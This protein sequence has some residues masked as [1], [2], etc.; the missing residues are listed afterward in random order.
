[1]VCAAKVIITRYISSPDMSNIASD[2]PL[3]IVQL[4]PDLE[5]GGVERGT[6]EI[7]KSAVDRGWNSW[8]VSRKGRL[9]DEL[10]ADGGH[11]IDWGIGGKHP[12]TLRW[13][14]RLMRFCRENRIDI[15]HARSR[16]PAW[17]AYLAWRMMPPTAR[18]FFVTTVHGLNSVNVYSR[19][20]T[21]GERVI[22]VSKTAHEF[23]MKN[24]PDVDKKR[25]ELIYRGVDDRAFP[26]GYK[27]DSAWMA[28]W[29]NQ[30]PQLRNSNLILLPGRISRRKG[31]SEFVDLVESLRVKLPNVVGMIIGGWGAKQNAYVNEIK[32]KIDQKGLKDAI[33]WAGHRS[34][35]KEIY[36]ASDL[37]LSLSRKPESFGRTIVEA[38]SMGVRCAGLD[39]GGVGEILERMYPQG[40]LEMS[41]DPR[42]WAES[43]QTLLSPPSP[44]P[45]P[46]AFPLDAVLNQELDCYE[47]WISNR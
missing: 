9:V 11:H 37:V 12:W 15:L 22:A 25:I 47:R 13:V 38:L 21:R 40:R 14:P 34:D 32:S 5:S 19:I 39:H 27:P 8:V 16:M 31:H 45:L 29:Y 43:V 20:M 42:S 23:V 7:S 1:M 4:L 46:N 18:P 24:Y 3:S 35:M 17:V 26:S 44:K 28:N 36:A 6:L 30:F 33:L 2:R 41:G 10:I